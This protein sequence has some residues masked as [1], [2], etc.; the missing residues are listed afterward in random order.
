[1]RIVGAASAFP[2]HYYPQAVLTEA[3]I[4]YWGSRLEQWI[5]RPGQGQR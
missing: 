5:K 3:A 1:M 2:E 4:Q